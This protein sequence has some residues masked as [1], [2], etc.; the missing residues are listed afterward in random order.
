MSGNSS[1]SGRKRKPGT[2]QS[3][4]P[5]INRKGRPKSF[6][7]FRALALE[8][9]D[10]KVKVACEK[11]GINSPTKESENLTVAAFILRKWAFS[12]EPVLQKAFAE[13]AF[14]KVPETLNLS[15]QLYEVLIGK[16]NK[17]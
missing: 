13:V 17:D 6:D 9:A 7:T 2:F 3:G 10:E 8:I 12:S 16:R 4:D 14:G 1:N 11:L 5:R 15:E